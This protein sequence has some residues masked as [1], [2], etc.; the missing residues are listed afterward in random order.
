VRPPEPVPF[1]P[2]VT[3]ERLELSEDD[4]VELDPEEL[5][6][7]ITLTNPLFRKPRGA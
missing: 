5:S 3:S 4:L 1:D 7:E 2:R 6:K